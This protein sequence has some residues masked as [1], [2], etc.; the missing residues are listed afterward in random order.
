MFNAE[1]DKREFKDVCMCVG[2]NVIVCMCKRDGTLAC[3]SFEALLLVVIVVG[4]LLCCARCG[5]Q[6]AVCLSKSTSHSFG[7]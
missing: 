5:Q 1:D 7:R 4:G 2:V 3:L 6:T